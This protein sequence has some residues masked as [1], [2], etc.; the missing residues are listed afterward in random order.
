M[1]HVMQDMEID[2]KSPNYSFVLVERYDVQYSLESA[3]QDKWFQD[4]P[5]YYL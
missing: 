5:F 2:A 3:F 4:L 1:H